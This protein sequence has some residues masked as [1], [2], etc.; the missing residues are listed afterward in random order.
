MYWN[1]LTRC[2][3]QVNLHNIVSIICFLVHYHHASKGIST[4]K[5]KQ[6]TCSVDYSLLLNS[7]LLEK[8]WL[9]QSV[10][11]KWASNSNS[12][13]WP[14]E[15]QARAGLRVNWLENSHRIMKHINKVIEIH[16]GTIT[17]IHKTNFA[18]TN[19]CT[20]KLRPLITKTPY[21]THAKK[22]IL[23]FA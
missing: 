16:T 8:R 11:D 5:L 3:C 19:E 21:C 12:H 10:S 17:R 1:N 14:T 13:Y 23:V 6:Q 15:R 22:K 4:N 18:Q 2:V 20:D 9:L 7:N